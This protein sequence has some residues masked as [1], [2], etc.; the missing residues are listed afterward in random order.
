MRM[1]QSAVGANAA[2]TAVVQGSRR[3]RYDGLLALARQYAGGLRR[4]GVGAGDSVAVVLPNG[5]EFVAALFACAELRA[6]LLPLDPRSTRQ[7]WLRLAAESHA[8]IAITDAPRA[9]SLAGSGLTAVKP[10]ALAAPPS[11]PLPAGEFAGPVL[12][13]YTSGSTDSRKRLCSTQANLVDEA[14]NFVDTADLTAADNILCTIPL[15]HSYGLGNC[16]LDA[17]YTGSTLVLLENDDTPFAAQCPHVLELI[18]REKIRFYP[19]VPYQFQVLASLPEG[20]GTDLAGLRLCVSSGDVLPRRTYERFLQRFGLPI[21]SLYGSTEAGSIAINLDPAEVLQFGSLGPPLHNVQ[22][23]IR[24]E[25]GR[26]LP[27]GESGQIWVKSPVLPPGGYDNRPELTAAV[28]QGGYYNTGDLGM[29][30]TRGHLMMTGR[31]Q[32]FVDVGGHKVDIAEVEEALQGHPLVREAA[33]LAVEVPHLGTLIK[34]VVVAAN[35]CREGDLLAHC[36]ERLA[37]FKVPR[38]VEFRDAL[39]RS[40][41]GKV[42]KSE[43][44]AVGDYLAG[45]R[46]A[47]F[48][49]AWQA[50]AKEGKARQ[51]ELL[52]ARIREQA[53]QCLQCESASLDGSAPFQEMGF[54]SL[55]ATE[56][57]LRLVKLTG[58]PLSISVLWNYPNIDALAGALRAQ[59][60]AE[61]AD[62]PAV[63]ARPAPAPRTAANLDELFNEVDALSDAEVDAAFRAE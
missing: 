53:A 62:Q 41:L 42:L 10:E 22:I 44:G 25:T 38:L 4:L 21:R 48:A 18:R 13:L 31:K 34:A 63:M 20:V 60:T 5:P 1:L 59:L 17:V 57:H 52:A 28:F 50:A 29:L 43:L 37:A 36:R 24:D 16:L 56:L 27:A 2:K 23:R 46:Q 61:S 7:E 14:R 58:L 54:D 47:E 55:R 32:T 11:E 35:A 15:H 49:R 33:A 30:D 9:D 8:R 51:I 40:P 39:P 6:V 19:G 45:V 26:N 3:L 12:Y